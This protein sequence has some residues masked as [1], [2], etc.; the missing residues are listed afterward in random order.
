MNKA[1]L[2]HVNITVSDPER[3]AEFLCTLFDW[4]VR[5]SGPSL[6]GGF[7]VHV[8][9]NTDYLALYCPDESKNIRPFKK[10]RAGR[11]CGGLNHVAV[12]VDDLKEAER[13]VKG[14]GFR[15]VNHADYEPGERFYFY[16][17]DGIEYEV[18]SYA[19]VASTWELACL[20]K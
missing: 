16:D 12:T 3:T 19:R 18:V 17:H 7:T 11:E 6:F 20:I 13:R 1:N 15:P 9:T 2:E 5:W 10:S 8:G 14:V 4:Q